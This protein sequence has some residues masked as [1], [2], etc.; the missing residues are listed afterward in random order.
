MEG[1]KTE[2]IRPPLL[3]F[4]KTADDIDN[5]DT[6]LDLLYGLLSDQ[7]VQYQYLKPC[8]VLNLTMKNLQNGVQIPEK[9]PIDNYKA[10]I[11]YFQ[12]ENLEF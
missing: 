1:T 7:N 5:V 11:K 9:F 2:I 4:H 12:N 10:A 8:Y 3:Q 6:A